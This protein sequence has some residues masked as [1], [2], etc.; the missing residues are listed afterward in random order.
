MKYLKTY[1]KVTKNYIY[2]VTLDE[3]SS[4]E[5][6]FPFSPDSSPNMG[7]T[8]GEAYY[9]IAVSMVRHVMRDIPD[10]FWELNWCD[11]DKDLTKFGFVKQT[12]PTKIQSIIYM[13]ENVE[14]K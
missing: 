3:S 13:K 1:N 7:G 12:E 6:H 8:Y 9:H 5:I 10:F 14:V 11:I 4:F 2:Y